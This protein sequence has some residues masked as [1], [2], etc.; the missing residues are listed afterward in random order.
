MVIRNQDTGKVSQDPEIVS[1][2]MTGSRAASA[3]LG[4]ALSF[5]SAASHFS[6]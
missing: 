5:L 2:A 4:W 1:E 3:A 6:P